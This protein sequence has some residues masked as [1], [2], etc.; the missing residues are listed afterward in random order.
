MRAARVLTVGLACSALILG[1]ALTLPPSAAA[2]S[3]AAGPLTVTT[4]NDTGPGSLRT[5][6]TT[7]SGVASAQ[8]ICIDTTQVTAAITLASDFPALSAGTGALTIDGNGATV[9]GN[10]HV[11]LS[12][13]SSASLTVDSLTITGA[14]A[15]TLGGGGIGSTGALTVTNSTIT[16]NTDNSGAGGG[17]IFSA[18]SVSVTNSTIAHNS[19]PAGPGGGILCLGCSVSVANS[20]ISTNIDDGADASGGLEGVPVVV[21]NSTVTDNTDGGIAVLGVG[22]GVGVLTLV[23]STVA[24][25]TS[26]GGGAANLAGAGS[27]GHLPNTLITFG[28]IVALPESGP[29]GIGTPTNCAGFTTTTSHGFNFTDDTSC[30]LPAADTHVGASPQLGALANNGGPTQTLLPLTGSP[31]IDAIP[32]A[33]CQADGAAGITTDQR[34]FARPD[35]ASPNCDIGAVEVLSAP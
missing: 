2:T 22:G 10:G 23:Y 14:T 34:G 35:A 16:S 26:P 28:S 33:S 19:S 32:A 31:L 17:G 29:G 5:A 21:T 27:L 18:T 12:D 9:N 6:L 30:G 24:G 13:L 3:C 15:G 25:N 7:A 4:S 11:V 1:W 8:T 20:T